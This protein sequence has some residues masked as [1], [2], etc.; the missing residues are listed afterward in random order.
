MICR[1][2]SD[3][4]LNSYQLSYISLIVVELATISLSVNAAERAADTVHYLLVAAL[5]TTR[6][7]LIQRITEPVMHGYFITTEWVAKPW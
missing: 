7:I 5:A 3:T 6:L 2:I 4:A 1:W